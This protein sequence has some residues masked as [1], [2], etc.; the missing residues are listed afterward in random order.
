M[1]NF[2]QILNWVCAKYTQQHGT[3]TQDQWGNIL[4]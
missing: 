2:G 1:T 4:V 3:Q